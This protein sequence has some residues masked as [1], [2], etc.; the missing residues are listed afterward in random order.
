MIQIILMLIIVPKSIYPLAKARGRNGL[1]WTLIAI[2]VFFAVELF[3][4]F[5]Y[6]VIYFLGVFLFGW[7]EAIE[8]QSFTF[9]VD[10]LA[11][12]GGL[13]GVEILRRQLSRTQPTLILSPPPPPDTF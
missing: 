6:T 4:I 9:F 5:L 3:I 8:K 13:S 12:V 11:L 2:G 10:L 7:S 1:L